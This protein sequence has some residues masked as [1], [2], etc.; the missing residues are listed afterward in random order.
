VKLA[1]DEIE[2]IGEVCPHGLRRTFAS[3][4]CAVGD[5]PA[6]TR[7]RSAT[8]RAV[9][10]EDVHS[11]GEAAERPKPAEQRPSTGPL[12]GHEWAQTSTKR[13]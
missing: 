2:T 1:E 7:R 11:G 3:H 12:N 6:Y 8:R 13:P 9:H 5:D 4:R 10:L